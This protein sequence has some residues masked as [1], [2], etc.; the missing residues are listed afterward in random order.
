MSTTAARLKGPTAGDGV[1]YQA[2]ARFRRA[3]RAYLQVSDIAARSAGLTPA[4]HQLLL[5]IKGTESG[6][7]PT[8]AQV[9]DW[10]KLRHHSAV[11]LVDRAVAAGLMV[12]EAD[13]SGGRYQRLVL[14]PQ[15]EDK[16]A[17][18]AAVHRQEIRRF[19]E[20]MFGVTSRL[21]L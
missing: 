8:I 9:A 6:Q 10:L 18:L 13:F 16:L 21:S 11:E 20:E 14:S 1:D 12:R 2:L 17:G 4:Q 3:L 7:S 19:K 15:G 5:A